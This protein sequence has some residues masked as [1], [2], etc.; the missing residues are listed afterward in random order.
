MT[1]RR[2]ALPDAPTLARLHVEA[3]R[4]AYR[5][6]LPADVLATMTRERRERQWRHLLG[7]ADDRT[8]V[9]EGER[10]PVGFVA[11]GPP[12]DPDLAALG[13][14]GEV[15][16]IYLVAAAWGR[17]HGRALWEAAEGALRE[18]GDRE[19]A[20]W[21]LETN[22]RARGF[23]ERMGLTEDGWRKSER[24]GSAILEEVRYR[25]RLGPA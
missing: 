21:V 13:G 4:D 24:L 14:V 7:R 9:A 15:Y 22:A 5:E 10:G 11:V 19:V 23:Y 16:A 25:G 18:R 3:W 2:A 6:L 17:G 1:V 20:L 12:R 8:F